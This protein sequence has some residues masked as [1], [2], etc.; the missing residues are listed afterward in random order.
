M[1]PAYITKAFTKKEHAESF[2]AG[3]MRFRTLNYFQRAEKQGITNERQNKNKFDRTECELSYIQHD[4]AGD[5]KHTSSST[6]GLGIAIFCAYAENVELNSYGNYLVRIN[7][8]CRF[9]SEVK[10]WYDNIIIKDEAFFGRVRYREKKSPSFL[11]ESERPNFFCSKFHI[12]KPD[13]GKVSPVEQ[14]FFKDVAFRKDGE[15]VR[16]AFFLRYPQLATNQFKGKVNLYKGDELI[17]SYEEWCK[18]LAS[19]I[20]YGSDHWIEFIFQI[21]ESLQYFEKKY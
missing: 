11:S 18:S 8:P 21:E 5:F 6:P 7:N 15:E 1:E 12:N 16:M 14:V 17:S 4:P 9:F 20:Y 13:S 3:V 19:S 10:P 2:C